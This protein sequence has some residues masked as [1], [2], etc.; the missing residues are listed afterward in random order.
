MWQVFLLEWAET[1]L[2][3]LAFEFF[4]MSVLTK[5]LCTP[6]SN[7]LGDVSY[8]W[9]ICCPEIFCACKAPACTGVLLCGQ[10]LCLLP[11]R[12]LPV[13]TLEKEGEEPVNIYSSHGRGFH[14]KLSQAQPS[15]PKLTQGFIIILLRFWSSVPGGRGLRRNV[16]GAFRGRSQR[17]QSAASQPC[18]RNNLLTVG[19]PEERYSRSVRGLG[20]CS[21]VVRAAFQVMSFTI[22]V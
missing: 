14:Q 21:T 3:F 13:G 7:V 6:V 8:R 12:Q 5:R 2:L 4:S 20:C 16:K 11:E 15:G 18:S 19:E 22:Y 9:L 17:P 1:G 10:L